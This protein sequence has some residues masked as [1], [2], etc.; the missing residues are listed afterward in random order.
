M[1]AAA[2]GE[3]AAVDGHMGAAGRAQGSHIGEAIGIDRKI[4]APTDV[5][6]S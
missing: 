5:E 6:G 4:V 3:T 2:V 1:D